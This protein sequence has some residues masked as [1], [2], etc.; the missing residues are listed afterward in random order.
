[1]ANLKVVE[2]ESQDVIEFKVPASDTKGHSTRMWFRCVPSMGR[3]VEE[4]VQ[5]RAFP[6]RVRGDLLRHAL[7]RHM[8]WLRSVGPVKTVSGQVDAILEIM[9]EEEMN[10]DFEVV[11]TTLEKRID[12]YLKA[13]DEREAARLVLMVSGHI[14]EMPDGFWKGR[15]EGRLKDRFGDMLKK[16]AK[17]DLGKVE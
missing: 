8:N 15:Y 13:G 9:R 10:G 17:L 11:F 1:M 3:Q 12:G 16:A 14:K 5:S 2:G 7:H 6:Y 4:I